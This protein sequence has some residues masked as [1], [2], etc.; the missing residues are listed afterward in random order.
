MAKARTSSTCQT[1]KQ[2]FRDR[3]AAQLALVRIGN[4]NSS[5]RRETRAYRCPHCRGWHL[6]SR[7]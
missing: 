1:G 2:R 3:L 7:P 4:S 6:T 5:R